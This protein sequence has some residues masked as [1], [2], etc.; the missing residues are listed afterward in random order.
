LVGT[1][2]PGTDVITCREFGHIGMNCV[3]RH[4]RKKDTTKR[5]FICTE[6]G[7]LAKNY[8]NSGIIEDEKKTKV[9]NI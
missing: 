9:D 6:L 7:H 1:I 4:M 5:C 2:I 8:M 3:K